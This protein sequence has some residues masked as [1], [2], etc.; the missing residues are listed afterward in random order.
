MIDHI[1]G[2]TDLE[3]GTGV[4]RMLRSE[5]VAAIC[6]AL[7]WPIIFRAAREGRRPAV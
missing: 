7:L 1:D 6:V 2:D 3:R 5:K 4:G